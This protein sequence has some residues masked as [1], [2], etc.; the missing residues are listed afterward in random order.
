MPLIYQK[1]YFTEDARRNPRVLYVFG[2]N[3][4]RVG[5]GGQAGAM[6]Y[7]PNAIGVAT[8]YGPYETFGETPAQIIAQKKIIDDDM[9]PLFEHLKDGSI[10]VWPADGIGTGLAD[11]ARVAPTT[12]EYI[13]QKLKALIL[14]GNLADKSQWAEAETQ[15]RSHVS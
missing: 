6:R 5:T 2:D 12:L 1:R 7:E 10:V 14:V 13:E 9:K 4:R 8:K 3:V 11:L 15:A